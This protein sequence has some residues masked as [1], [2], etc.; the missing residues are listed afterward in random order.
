MRGEVRAPR[1]RVL[2]DGFEL[3]GV[4]AAD[5]WSTNH[6]SAD[7]FRVRL[8]AGAGGLDAVDVAGVRLD[9]QVSDGADWTSLVLGEADAAGLDVLRGVVDVEGRDLTALLIDSR[10]DETFANRTASEIVELLGQRH[11]LSVDADRTE[12][13]VGRYYQSEHGRL[14]MG[15]S[16]RTMS[17]WDLLAFLAA[18]EGF[19]LFAEG[20]R[21]RFG[22]RAAGAAIVVGP[23]DCLSLHLDHSLG[24]ARA[25][26]V[27]VRS[28][29]QRGAESVVQTARGGGKGRSWKHGLVKPNLPPEEAQRLA[30]RVLADLVRHER[31][32]RLSM[33]GSVG[34]TP[35]HAIEVR[36]TETGWDRIYAV[37]EIS[38]HFDVRH[39][40]V[41]RLQLQGMS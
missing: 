25:I 4:M 23:P 8:A 28:W 41:Q 18:R 32:V 27:T 20:L 39:G 35:R 34:I 38:R 29:D 2:A 40:F 22:R 33:P 1:L 21:L 16:A 37:G 3:P 5:V 9:V 14:T 36:G 19:D 26:E 11:G 12:T 31:T 15:Q 24:M 10:V 13:L 6:F 7:R 17:E 30:E